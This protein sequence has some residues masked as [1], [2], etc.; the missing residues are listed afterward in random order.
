MAARPDA[1]LRSYSA[2]HLRFALEAFFAIGQRLRDDRNPLGGTIETWADLMARIGTFGI[3]LRLLVDFFFPRRR[4]PDDVFAEEFFTTGAWWGARGKLPQALRQARERVDKELAHLTV[5]WIS[6]RPDS[7]IWDTAPLLDAMLVLVRRFVDG[8]SPERLDQS[9]AILV[10][11]LER[12]P[13]D[14]NAPLLPETLSGQVVAQ[15]SP[16]SAILSPHLRA[17][18]P[19]NRREPAADSD[20]RRSVPGGGLRDEEQRAGP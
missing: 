4:R 6:G 2:E 7:K 10:D 20:G 1:Y 5:G 8:A 13:L 16:V 17:L 3:L 9:V 19:S 15:T 18:Q 12:G 14:L 11:R